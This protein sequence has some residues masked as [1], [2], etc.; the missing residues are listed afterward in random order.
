M[1]A[2]WTD[3]RRAEASAVMRR[4]VTAMWQE[5]RRREM[6]SVRER[7]REGQV[8]TGIES[9]AYIRGMI[10]DMSAADQERINALATILRCVSGLPGGVPAL[11]LVAAEWQVA[12]EETNTPEGE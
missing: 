8:V 9:L 12:A 4:T 11:A 3:E 1:R 5:R 10:G 7:M 2:A 6:E